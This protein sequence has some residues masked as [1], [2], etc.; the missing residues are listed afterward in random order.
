MLQAI[1]LKHKN[2]LFS[3]KCFPEEIQDLLEFLSLCFWFPY[4]FSVYNVSRSII[5]APQCVFQWLRNQ[6]VSLV[7]EDG[8]VVWWILPFN[9]WNCSST[10]CKIVPCGKLI[11]LLCLQKT[12]YEISW[13]V[14]FRS[15]DHEN[16]FLYLH[17]PTICICVHL[18]LNVPLLC[19]N[20]YNIIGVTAAHKYIHFHN[21]KRE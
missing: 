10:A 9:F 14:L 11:L 18:E 20:S 21:L 1:T 13:L 7:Y 16:V 19:I 2:V 8:P 15:L 6:W 5:M 17:F 12:G 4:P 3:L